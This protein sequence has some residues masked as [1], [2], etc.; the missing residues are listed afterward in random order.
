MFK[1]VVEY[2][3]NV[4]KDL[5]DKVLRM[6]VQKFDEFDGLEELKFKLK[7]LN[8]ICDKFKEENMGLVI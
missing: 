7:E 4:K 2:L 1:F 6:E 3:V 8:E 5:E